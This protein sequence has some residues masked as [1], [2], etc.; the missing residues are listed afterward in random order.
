M[1]ILGVLQ[2][3]LF[4]WCGLAVIFTS[5]IGE[6]RPETFLEL[7]KI[8]NRHPLTLFFSYLLFVSIISLMTFALFDPGQPKAAIAAGLSWKTIADPVKRGA[9]RL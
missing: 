7:L 8:T 5:F 1:S 6:V 3:S 4:Y 2:N 9:E